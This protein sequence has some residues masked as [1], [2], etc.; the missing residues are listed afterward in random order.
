MNNQE[1][2]DAIKIAV[3]R[4]SIKSIDEVLQHPPGRNPERRLVDMFL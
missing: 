2:V 1:F 4:D 3:V